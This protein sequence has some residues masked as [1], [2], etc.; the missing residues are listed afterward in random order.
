MSLFIASRIKGA[1]KKGGLEE[2]QNKY[3]IYFVKTNLYL[4]EKPEVDTILATDGLEDC[5]VKA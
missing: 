5:I 4:D 1:Y 3:R 2:A